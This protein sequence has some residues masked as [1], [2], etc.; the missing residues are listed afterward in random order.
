LNAGVSVRGTVFA[1]CRHQLPGW[2]RRRWQQVTL[3]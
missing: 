2:R 3:R 1:S